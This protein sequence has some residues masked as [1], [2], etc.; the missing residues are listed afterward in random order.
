MVSRTNE[1]KLSIP[2]EPPVSYQIPLINLDHFSSLPEKTQRQFV[3]NIKSGLIGDYLQAIEAVKKW[4]NLPTDKKLTWL[5]VPLILYNKLDS[6]GEPIPFVDESVDIERELDLENLRYDEERYRIDAL[7]EHTPPA[8]RGIITLASYISIRETLNR[9]LE[10][11]REV[12]VKGADPI[13]SLGKISLDDLYEEWLPSLDQKKITSKDL[14][15][16]VLVAFTI[17]K[18]QNGDERAIKTLYGL[19]K[20]AANAVAAKFGRR[21]GIPEKIRDLKSDVQVFLWFVITGFRVTDIISQL[22]EPDSGKV[23]KNIP[24]WVKNFYIN[25]L[26]EYVPQC[27]ENNIRETQRNRDLIEELAKVPRNDG[28]NQVEDAIKILKTRNAF[29]DFQGIGMLNPYT[30]FQAKNRWRTPVRPN[31]FNNYSFLPGV[32]KMGPKANL[33]IWLMGPKDKPHW[34]KLYQLLKAQ[35]KLLIDEKKG[36]TTT[37]DADDNFNEEYTGELDYKEKKKVPFSHLWNPHDAPERKSRKVRVKPSKKSPS[38]KSLK[39]I[40]DELRKMGA[41]P[42]DAEI[43]ALCKVLKDITQEKMAR[44]CELKSRRQVIRI[45]K[46]VKALIFA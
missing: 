14:L 26:T 42:R 27:M 10:N 24:P 17:K 2:T 19:Y 45:C 13:F 20:D 21:F 30:P 22:V 18:A 46:K 11:Y 37:D 43:F 15:D 23:I 1:K 6:F 3:E 38:T 16:Q 36:S 32:F 5:L 7:E 41:S 4:K 33:T 31:R 8:F 28:R 40:V 29:L 12:E 39:E 44:L 25:Y 9:D 35:Y 34:G